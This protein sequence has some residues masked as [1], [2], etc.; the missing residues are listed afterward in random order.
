MSKLTQPGNAD[1]HYMTVVCTP[2]ATAVTFHEF[3]DVD[4][5]GGPAIDAAKEALEAPRTSAYVGLV[6]FHGNTGPLFRNETVLV[7]VQ[8]DAELRSAIRK[9]C[10]ARGRA[11]MIQ[12]LTGLLNADL[13]QICGE[14]PEGSDAGPH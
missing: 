1:L 5:E 11:A 8:L 9:H 7:P 13:A 10:G 12:F 4:G 14:E 3:R 6:E 2:E